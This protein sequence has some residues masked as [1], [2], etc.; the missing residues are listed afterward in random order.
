M[1]SKSTKALQVVN[2]PVMTS[3]CE[4]PLTPIKETLSTLQAVKLSAPI[5]Q[6][7][8]QSMPCKE[9]TNV[10]TARH[11]QALQGNT[12]VRKDS[13][14]TAKKSQRLQ[15]LQGNTSTENISHKT[16]EL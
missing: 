1:N 5:P 3:C 7:R 13:K 2:H 12:S 9:T 10:Q 15:L 6:P 14:E 11:S 4:D 8:K 16:I